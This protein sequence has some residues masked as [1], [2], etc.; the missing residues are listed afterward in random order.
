MVEEQVVER[1]IRGQRGRGGLDTC[2]PGERQC[3]VELVRLACRRS[4]RAQSGKQPPFGA[5]P[6][7]PLQIQ[8]GE[9]EVFAVPEGTRSDGPTFEAGNQLVVCH[10]KRYITTSQ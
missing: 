4:E 2:H 7:V 5:G 8:P 6:P 10:S 9:A 1:V 3:G